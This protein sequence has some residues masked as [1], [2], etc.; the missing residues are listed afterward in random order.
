MLKVLLYGLATFMETGIGVWIFG[1]MFPKRKVLKRKQYFSMWLMYLWIMI[2]AYTYPKL[3]LHVNRIH[4]YLG[5]II[6]FYL[7]GILGMTIFIVRCKEWDLIKIIGF[8]LMLAQLE[9]QYWNSYQ[10]IIMILLGNIVPVLYLYIF[11]QCSLW[12]AYL[13]EI[14]YLANIALLKEPYV[15]YV[16]TFKNRSFIDFFLWPREHLYSEILYVI[17]IYSMILLMNKYICISRWINPLLKEHKKYLFIMTCAEVYVLSILMHFG[18]GKITENNLTITLIVLMI[19]VLGLLFV[20]LKMQERLIK[21]EK[22]IL[23]MRFET[24]TEQYKELKKSY[25]KYRCL[26]HDEK[27]MILYLNECLDNRDI[28][29][30]KKI[31]RGYKE[32]TFTK[33]KA[34]WTGISTLDF[35]L[36]IKIEKMR[37]QEIEFK[38][39]SQVEKIPMEEL[40]F[41]MMMGNLLDNAIESAVKCRKGERYADK[42]QLLLRY[43][44]S[45]YSEKAGNWKDLRESSGESFM[46]AWC[47]G[48]P[49]I[50]LSRMKLE[51]LFPEDMQIKKDRLNAAD[52]LFYGEQ[53]EKICLCHGM[54]GNLLIM[55]K[56]LRKYGNK[57][58]KEQYEALCDCLL[59]QLDHPAK[60]SGTEYLNL[61][62]MNG[63]SGTGMALMEIL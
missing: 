43:E 23:N 35:M 47:H 48:A 7:S 30:A 53:D 41:I 14:I 39:N 5:C 59:F 27:H 26:L 11:Y 45:L 40:D 22:N 17:I 36:N 25:D 19:L 58:M 13:W 6:A 3:F 56:Y 8:I 24:M 37:E 16:G 46:N 28:K 32:L 60:I 29:E 55:K 49:G 12:D 10:S 20:Y 62:F 50:L 1:Q 44:D 33:D 63:I 57:K 9:C 51:E 18:E 42:I 15:A 52:S 38:I 2:G 31:L 4:G 34:I 21:S 61:A 54:S